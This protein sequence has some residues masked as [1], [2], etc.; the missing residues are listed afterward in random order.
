MV[1]IAAAKAAKAAGGINPK[2]AVIIG[3][4]GLLGLAYMTNKIAA[5]PGAAIG[6]VGELA[7]AANEWAAGS[8]YFGQGDNFARLTSQ[9]PDM[10]ENLSA[11]G[12]RTT[13]AF[14]GGLFKDPPKIEPNWSYF[15]GPDEEDEWQY[16]TPRTAHAVDA[17][18]VPI[19]VPTP[20]Y[21][22]ATDAGA[23]IRGWVQEL[24]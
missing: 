21:Q 9:R 2:T 15:G 14:F 11:P 12:F 24:F 17:Q 16:G 23:R 4:V 7:T 5:I 19:A 18:G 8:D 13:K 10:G 1:A 6:K 3:V 22:G 20:V